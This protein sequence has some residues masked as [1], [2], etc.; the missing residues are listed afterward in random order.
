FLGLKKYS[1]ASI[2]AAREGD[3]LTVLRWFFS[4]DPF[5]I[6]WGRRTFAEVCIIMFSPLTSHGHGIERLL[7]FTTRRIVV[8]V[9]LG[10]VASL[11]H[12]RPVQSLQEAAKGTGQQ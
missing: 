11:A 5:R 4:T 8:V 2:Q 7:L 1:V 9:L 3:V 10:L 6:Y 12:S